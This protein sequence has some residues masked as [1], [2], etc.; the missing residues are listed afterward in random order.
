[1]SEG[2]PLIVAVTGG[3]GFVGRATLVELQRRGHRVKALVRDAAQAKLPPD[4]DTVSGSITS[5]QALRTLMTGADAVIHIAGAISA[6]DAAGFLAVNAAPVPGIAEAAISAG[7][8]RFVHVSSLAAREPAISPYAASKRAGE[9]AIVRYGDRL[10]LVILRPPAIYGPGDRATLPLFKQLT[11]PLA[12]IP[13]R[14]TARFSLIHVEDVARVLA[15][16]C[17]SRRTGTFELGDDRPQGYNWPELIDIAASVEGRRIGLLF[18]PKALAA[19]G[20]HLSGAVARLRRT[21]SM[22]TPG[23]IAELYHSN[24]VSAP[25]GWPLGHPT[26]FAEGL[27]ETLAWYRAAGWL[28]K[29]S[30]AT[31]TTPDPTGKTNR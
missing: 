2:K 4:I 17:E 19:I 11:G 13:A 15:E 7:V 28:P 20:G 23:K 22:V 6:L 18:L 8:S 24:W 12:I 26:G 27:A 1:M 16:A 25:P 5:A 21:P 31:T 29:R 9:E 3:T 10:S 14:R 30:G